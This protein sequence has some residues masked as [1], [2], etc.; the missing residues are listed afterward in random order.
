MNELPFPLWLLLTGLAI[1]GAFVGRFLNICAIRFPLHGELKKQLQSVCRNWS[2]C[3]KCSS[4][5]SFSERIP[6]IGWLLNGRRCHK[7]AS[8]VSPVF[9]VIELITTILFVVVYSCEIQFSDTGIQNGLR[10]AEG[11]RGPEAVTT[12][13]TPMVWLHLRYALHMVM[14][15]GLIVA[16]EIDRRL[17]IIPDGSTVPITLFAIVSSFVIGQSYI[18]PIWFQDASTVAMLE[19]IVPVILKP[20]MVPWDPTVFIQ[21]WPHLHGLLVSIAGAVAGAGSIWI[22]RQIGFMV[23]KQE[24]MGFGDVVLMAMIGSVIGWQPVLAVFVFAPMLAMFAA[25]IN[26]IAHRDNE[27]PY[28]PFLSVAT[29][30]LLL[31]WPI[32]WPFPKRFFDMGPLLLVM[33]VLMVILLAVSLQLVQVIKRLLG[34]DT[35]VG[36]DA[37]EADWTSADHLFFYNYERPDI[38][39]GEWQRD[40][41]PGTRAGQGLKRSHDWRN[42]DY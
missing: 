37:G 34:I 19:P 13:W 18:V 9:S 3:G 10:S 21:T 41:W 36:N 11:P 32:L 42:K 14:I 39:T 15:C 8:R 12:L 28:G 38:Q 2:V 22:V 40:L 24:A 7:C 31:A 29:L 30:I 1:L 5:P 20:L 35:S 23:L 26:W 17:R 6:V 25:I 4:S 33:V 27:I 16:T